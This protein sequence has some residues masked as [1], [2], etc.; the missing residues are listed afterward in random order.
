MSNPFKRGGFRSTANA[1][2]QNNYTTCAIRQNDHIGGSV[3]NVDTLTFSKW[4]SAQ[5]CEWLARNGFESYF[6]LNSEGIRAHKW[7]KNG[8]H[9]LQAT[10]YDYERVSV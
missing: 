3:C 8:L 9:L 7:I 2:L 1:R 5:V 10:Q 4:T 6:P